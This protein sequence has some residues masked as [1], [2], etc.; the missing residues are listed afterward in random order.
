M[1]HYK[2][3]SGHVSGRDMQRPEVRGIAE[4]FT[5][6]HIATESRK[7][8]ATRDF[9]WY[10]T[11]SAHV[12]Y[13]MYLGTY[14]GSYMVP[15]INRPMTNPTRNP[16]GLHCSRRQHPKLSDSSPNTSNHR[17]G[18]CRMRRN[19]GSGIGYIQIHNS[20]FTCKSQIYEL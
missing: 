8:P 5:E 13:Y 4:E 17:I 11:D 10:N 6:P 19:P 9:C 20:V 15:V 12:Q 3:R 14:V 18:R 16:V 2:P 1:I 7:W